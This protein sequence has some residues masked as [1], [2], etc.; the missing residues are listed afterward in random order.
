MTSSREFQSAIA[1]I[2]RFYLCIDIL[3]ITITLCV[4]QTVSGPTTA[5]T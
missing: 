2:A 1:Y 3:G 4:F 5:P